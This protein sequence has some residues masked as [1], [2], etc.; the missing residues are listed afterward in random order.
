MEKLKNITLNEAVGLVTNPESPAVY[1]LVKLY[2]DTPLD[3]VADAEGFYVMEEIQEE[4]AEV[5]T[6]SGKLIDHGRIV[7][8]Y[9]ANPPRTVK[10]IAEDMG[11]TQQT[12]INHLKKEG[13]YKKEG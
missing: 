11:I 13:I 2:G 6:P 1:M 4:E 9:K 10:W 7:A 5:K 3:A 8:L 12:V